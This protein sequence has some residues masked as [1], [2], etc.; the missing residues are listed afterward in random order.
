MFRVFAGRDG[1][2]RNHR[3]VHDADIRG[4]QSGGNFRFFKLRLQT[5]V[6]RL[7]CFRFAFQDVVLDHFFG[8][9]IHFSLLLIQCAA[10]KVLVLFG[11]TIFT[12]KL[13]D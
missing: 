13:R 1:R 2:R 10:Q 11:L 8:H 6:Q 9:G 5:V 4:F 7:I 3:G 12:F